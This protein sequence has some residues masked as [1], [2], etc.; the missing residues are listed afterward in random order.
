MAQEP[1]GYKETFV[2]EIYSKLNETE[3][4]DGKVYPKNK[5]V[6]NSYTYDGEYEDK[7]GK[8][9]EYKGEKV[10]IINSKMV[11]EDGQAVKAKKS[12]NGRVYNDETVCVLSQEDFQ[13]LVG[14]LKTAEFEE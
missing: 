1:R 6:I 7:E 11:L 5:I 10:K 4:K 12:V 14:F 13:D 2:E 8:I 3:S 9:V